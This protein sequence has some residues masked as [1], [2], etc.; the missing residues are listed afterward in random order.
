MRMRHIG[1]LLASFTGIIAPA[2]TAQ[3]VSE[4][5]GDDIVR[6][7]ASAG[8]KANAYPSFALLDPRMPA[9]GAS[10]EGFAVEPGFFTDEQGRSSFTIEIDPGTSLYGTGEVPGPLLRNGRKTVL[11]NSDSYGY[12]E[13]T[14]SL[15][16]SHP[17]V[18]AVRKDGSSF[19]VIG[20][21][22][23]RIEIDLTEDITFHAEGP[24][25][26]VIVIERDSPLEVVKTLA[27]LT[28]KI[29]MPPKWAIG[30]HQCR[31]SYYPDSQVREI[32]QGFRDRDLPADVIWMDIH[33]MDEY[34]V[35]R[36]DDELFPD[37]KGLNEYLLNELNFHNVWMIDPG[38][39]AET[40]RFPP[41]GYSVYEELIE[42]DHAVKTAHGDIYKG[43]VWPGWC[44][45]P[46]YTRQRTRDWWA[47]L[48]EGFMAQG[49][50]GVWNDMNEPAIFNVESKTMP[51]DNVHA[52]DP[53]MGGGGSHARFHNV[54]GMLMIK[55]T[56]EGV[57]KAN[58]DKRPFVLSRAI[59]LGGQRYAAGWSGD[60]SADWWDLEG[61][62]PM[63]LNMS[64]SGFPFYGPDIGGFIGNGDADQF[65][66]WFGYGVLF[67]FARGH[68]AVGNRQKEPWAFGEEVE[69]TARQALNNRYILLPYYYSLFYDAHTQGAPITQPVFFADPSDSALRTEDDMFLLG[70]GLLIKPSLTL[71]G[72]RAMTM[73]NGIWNKLNLE[74]ADNA[75]IPE[76]FVKGGSIIPT[77]PVMQY[78]SEKP[79]NPLT[80]VV[81]LDEDGRA[82]GSLYEDSGDGYSY[83][84]GDYLLSTYTAE[85]IG[86]RVEIRMTG[87]K[88]DRKRPIRDMHVRLLLGD[89]QEAFGS[90]RDGSVITI[91]LD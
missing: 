77:G 57:Q 4:S 29:P 59:Y 41:E 13:G 20:D 89:G 86:D 85:R 61:S 36:F 28:G 25:F 55:A 10:P 50:T 26:P 90:G 70:E 27:E 7:H 51:E 30:Y 54:Y 16:K 52:G 48:Y 42:G 5:I 12:K 64:L 14:Q 39:G 45:F 78:T 31:Y 44:V 58:P 67:P 2:V 38:I 81:S 43:E 22:T 65:E 63:V 24:E 76:F 82:W 15:Y 35:F 75:D 23:Y 3:V 83:Q 62:V 9:T 68:T 11:W 56:R 72:D 60:N 49:I 19:G 71:H 74:G 40:E 21:S 1:L 91:E 34:R 17:W 73:P 37:P 8:A 46:D 87:A 69:H 84:N 88:G 66:R 33:Y 18:L 53:E 47:G 6:F 32:A 79:L 80:L